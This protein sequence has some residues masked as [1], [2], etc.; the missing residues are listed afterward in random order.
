MG[1]VWCN[2]SRVVVGQCDVCDG[3][4]VLVGRCDVSGRVCVWGGSVMRWVAH[5]CAGVMRW[6]ARV[7]VTAAAQAD[8]EAVVAPE[9]GGGGAREIASLRAERDDA[10]VCLSVVFRH[11]CA[12]EHALAAHGLPQV[13]ARMEFGSD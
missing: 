4:C 13:R 8:V 12:L 10:L 7:C 9:G 6:V 1:G 11:K 2:V 3:A 5:V